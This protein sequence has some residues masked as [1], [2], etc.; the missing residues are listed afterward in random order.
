[1]QNYARTSAPA[2]EK[3]EQKRKDTLETNNVITYYK[4]VCITKHCCNENVFVGEDWLKLTV[5][6]KKMEDWMVGLIRH[7]VLNEP[8]I[9]TG[10]ASFMF[11]TFTIIVGSP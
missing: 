3:K 11:I 7:R 2:N 6:I 10:H 1:M 4:G 8:F 9:Q 5:Y